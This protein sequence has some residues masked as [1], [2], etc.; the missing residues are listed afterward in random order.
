MSCY[1]GNVAGV[2]ELLERGADS[3]AK[4]NRGDTALHIAS[5][6]ISWADHLPVV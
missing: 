1:K 6:A 4:D 5:G 3:E 2:I